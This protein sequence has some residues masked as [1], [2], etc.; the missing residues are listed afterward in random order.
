M[1]PVI[2]RKTVY[3]KVLGKCAVARVW[4]NPCEVASLADLKSVGSQLLVEG[5]SEQLWASSTSQFANAQG[6]LFL[7]SQVIFLLLSQCSGSVF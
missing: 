2:L 5:R 3:C 6:C 4:P 7:Y 1:E